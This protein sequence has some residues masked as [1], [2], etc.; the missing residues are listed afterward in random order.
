MLAFGEGDDATIGAPFVDG[1]V[2]TAEVVEQGRHAP[3]SPSRSAVV[4]IRA[5]RIGHRQHVTTVRIARDPDRRR[6]AVE[7]GCQGG[8]QGSE[9]RPALPTSSPKVVCQGEAKAGSC[10][11]RHRA[12]RRH[13]RGAEGEAR[14]QPATARWRRSPSSRR[15]TSPSSTKSCAR[16]PHRARGMGRAGQGIARRQAAARPSRQ[17]SCGQDGNRVRKRLKENTDGT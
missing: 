9:V 7:E 14:R 16:R 8:S 1:A 13:R 11:R 15:P 4:R 3:S 12:D 10:R 2:V 17:R 5:A 6:Q